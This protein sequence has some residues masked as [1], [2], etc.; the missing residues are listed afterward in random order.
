[1]SRF[2]TARVQRPIIYGLVDPRT[3]EVRYVGKSVNGESRARAH[4]HPRYRQEYAHTYNARWIESLLSQG[5][6]YVIRVLEVCD[7]DT[8]S[9][10]EQR[11]IAYGRANGWRLTNG[12][13]GGDGALNPSTESRAKRSDALRGRVFSDEHRAKISAAK[14]GV[15]Q[16]AEHRARLTE[17]RRSFPAEV[18]ARITAAT[19]SANIGRKHDAATRAK[20]SLS[21]GNRPRM[22]VNL[23]G[24][25]HA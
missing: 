17:V 18:R 13:D 4:R 1:V 16:S 12:T 21:Y 5:L 23:L 25:A 3:D 6:D 9:A 20:K 2:S 8:L 11:W 15:K 24:A 22:R 14:R 10:A 7:R 19:R